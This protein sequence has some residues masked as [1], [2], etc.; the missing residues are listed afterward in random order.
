MI[1]TSIPF[2]HGCCNE[3][4]FVNLCLRAVGHVT[5]KTVGGLCVLK[6]DTINLRWDEMKDLQDAA[7][8][9]DLAHGNS[10]CYSPAIASGLGGYVHFL[11]RSGKVIHSYDFKNK[12]IALS[13]MPTS[14]ASLSDHRLQGDCEAWAAL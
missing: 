12:T 11:D 5:K 3:L 2:L 1:I 14:H 10:V 7:F 4:F 8:F 6:L 13:S 9:L